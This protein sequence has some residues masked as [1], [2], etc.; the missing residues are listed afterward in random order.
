MFSRRTPSGA[1]GSAHQAGGPELRGDLV[2]GAGDVLGDLRAGADHLAGSEEQDDDL[3][4]VQPVDESGELLGLVLDLLQTEGDGD[5]VEVDLLLEVGGCDDV[6]HLDLGFDGDV[7]IGLLEILGHLRDCDLDVVPALG[8]RANDLSAPEDQGSGLGLL[9]PVDE[10]GELLRVVF[11]A[12]QSFLNPV[13]V[14]LLAEIG[15]G[16]HILDVHL[17]HL[18]TESGYLNSFYIYYCHKNKNRII[19]NV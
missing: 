14:E 2:Y 5:R 13:E 9:E 1:L 15:R 7:D 16:D 8:P 17:C 10:S 18:S 3:G 19:L 12:L 4:V 11:G 6:L